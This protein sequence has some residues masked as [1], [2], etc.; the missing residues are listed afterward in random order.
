MRTRVSILTVLALLASPGLASAQRAVFLVRHAEKMD[1]SRDAALSPAGEQRA[2]RLAA[3]LRS[4]GVRAVY[5]TEYQRTI[6]TG[7]PLAKALGIPL[8][9]SSAA[10]PDQLVAEIRTRHARDV[11][12]LV[13]HSNTVPTLIAA[14]GHPDPITIADPEYDNLF[15]LVPQPG[16]PPTLL[17]LK[18]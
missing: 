12:L 16:G 15:I 10:K 3:L 14:L 7:E 5:T 13:G 6:R 1:D 9:K 8:N 4:A 17:V 2:E 11:V 18:F